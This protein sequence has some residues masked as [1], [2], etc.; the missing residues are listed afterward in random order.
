MSQKLR[1]LGYREI[2]LSRDSV[3]GKAG[4]AV[5]GHEFHY[6]AIEEQIP[7]DMETV[8]TVSKRAGDQKLADGFQVNRTLG[9]Y[10]H[11]HFGSCPDVADAFINTCIRYRHERNQ[12]CN[13]EK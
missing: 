7:G 10:N 4:L 6:S 3:I 1:A 13:P 2:T 12:A 11:L 8:Y 5:R 9:S